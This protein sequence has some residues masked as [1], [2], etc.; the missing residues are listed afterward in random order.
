ME[1]RPPTP[2]KELDDEDVKPTSID[3]GPPPP[4]KGK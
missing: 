4:Y 3:V 1:P 2:P